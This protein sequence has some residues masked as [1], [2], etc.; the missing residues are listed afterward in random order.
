MAEQDFDRSE[1]ATPHKLK[2]ARKQGN[3]AKSPD[4]TAAAML[5]AMVGVLYA[6]GWSGLRQSA[7]LQMTMMNNV[8]R[9]DWSADGI[10]SWLGQ[11]ILNMLHIL[12]PLF[13]ALV[14]VAI[15][16]NLF[17]IGA[18][19]SFKPLAPDFTR[20]NPT[21]GFKRLFSMRT[22]YESFKSV[23]KL[24]VLGLI[25]YFAIR[26]D[27]SGLIALSALEQ[28]SYAR[29]LLNLTGSLT[30]KLALALVVIAIIDFA[31]TRWEFAKRMRMSKRDVKDELKNR[32]GDP[33]I[34]QRIR[35]LRKEMLKRSKAMRN[36]PSADVLITNPT[37]IAVALRYRHGAASAPQLVAKGAGELARK[38]RQVASRHH[39]PVV[40]NR[41]LARVLFREVDYEGFVPEKLYPQLA[42][43]M[44][45]VYAM[46]EARAKGAV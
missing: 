28:K 15:V 11:I 27:I 34:R 16:A 1:E 19:F 14:I 33:R 3:V 8:G 13:F 40:Q 37:R 12:A 6:Q 9:I 39:I 29:A 24:I 41:I 20:I 25:A 22:V 26:D 42:K 32:E 36:L 4:F 18:V 43:I 45:W 46:R 31:Y 44:V 10:S 2:E 21:T 17:Q 23:F 5:I 30:V 35:E 38:M 7:K